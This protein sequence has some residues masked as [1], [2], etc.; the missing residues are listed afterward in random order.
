M[1]PLK[2]N[3]APDKFPIVT[4]GLIILTAIVFAIEFFSSNLLGLINRFAI[5]S[6]LIDFSDPLTLTVF[7]SSIFLHAGFTHIFFNMWFLGIFGPNVEFSLGKIKY[8]LFYLT[9]GIVA[10]LAQYFFIRGQSTPMLGASGAIAAVLGYYLVKFP[11]HT[12]KTF[13]FFFRVSIIDLPS[14]IV[15][16]LWFVTQIFNGFGG[17]VIGTA[18]TSGTA[19]WAHIGGFVYGII[20]GRLARTK[21]HYESRNSR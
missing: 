11:H 16:G 17:L 21:K 5:I 1:I 12:I 9:G 14:Q 18:I 13:W 15:L 6:K 20:I 2:N 3:D 10:G 19:W 4:A 8:I 7:V